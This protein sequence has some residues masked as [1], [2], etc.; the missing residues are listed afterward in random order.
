MVNEHINDLLVGLPVQ[1]RPYIC[2]RPA[3]P[4]IPL[5]SR[6]PR[7]QPSVLIAGDVMDTAAS[8]LA[9][10]APVLKAKTGE[11]A[12]E[13]SEIA[14]LFLDTSNT[15]ALPGPQKHVE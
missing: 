7:P 11:E 5:H 14:A 1:V 10:F 4:D 12:F 9:L 15:S 2:L 6:L 3:C 8:W 13:A